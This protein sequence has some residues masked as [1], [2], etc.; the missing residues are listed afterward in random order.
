MEMK[1]YFPHG[2]VKG[3]W[4]LVDATDKVAG[5]LASDI[6]RYLRGKHRADY[7]PHVNMGDEIVVVNA[8][9]LRWTGKKLTDKVYYRHSG[10]PG[11]L[12]EVSLQKKMAVKPQE[13]LELAVKGMLPRGP[14]GNT[15][16]RRLRVYAGAEHPHAAQA[17]EK[18]K[19]A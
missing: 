13:V 10:Y 3:K 8:A 6:A 5:R 9:K 1:T 12:K 19:L 11:G 2:Q 16:M 14:L 7:T 4:Y 18:L 15:M 17:P